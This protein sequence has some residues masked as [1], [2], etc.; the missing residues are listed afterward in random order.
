MP[1]TGSRLAC[2]DVKYRRKHFVADEHVVLVTKHRVS[3]R[4]PTV[5]I[6]LVMIKSQL[7]HQL[8][9]LGTAAFDS[10]S[11]R[12]E[13]RAHRANKRDKQDHL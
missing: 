2:L 10:F 13:S 9:L 1:R 6:Q 8:R 12:P 4:Q 7:A 3:S 5:A 11:Q